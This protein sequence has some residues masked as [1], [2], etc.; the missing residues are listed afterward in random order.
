MTTYQG[1]DYNAEAGEQSA[2]AVGWRTP[3]YPMPAP[4]I[5]YEFGWSLNEARP[6]WLVITSERYDG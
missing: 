4:I 5:E 1:I 2:Y 6:V 3:R